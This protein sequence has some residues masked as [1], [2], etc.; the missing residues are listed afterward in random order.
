MEMQALQDY[1]HHEMMSLPN[2]DPSQRDRASSNQ[3]AAT[4]DYRPQALEF[5]NLDVNS[6]S[7]DDPFGS[8]LQAQLRS[9]KYLQEKNQLQ[10]K[11]NQM[12]E[13]YQMLA[14]SARSNREVD[15]RRQS[16]LQGQE[17]SSNYECSAFAEA[18]NQP[19]QEHVGGRNVLPR[20]LVRNSCS[21]ATALLGAR[22][23]PGLE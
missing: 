6:P 20:D 17:D 16:L 23:Q 9:Q 3:L 18:A 13:Q 19:T 14:K 4:G 2:Q 10:Q 21:D 11:L 22:E 12:H 1:Q 15:S 5:H 8:T 7:A